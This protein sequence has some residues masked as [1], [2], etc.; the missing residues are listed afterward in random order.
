MMSLH[1]TPQ[2]CVRAVASG[3]RHIFK[4]VWYGTTCCARKTHPHYVKYHALWR[5]VMRVCRK[6]RAVGNMG[7]NGTTTRGGV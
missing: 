1:T 6:V 2:I 3:N 4:P 5:S 7:R